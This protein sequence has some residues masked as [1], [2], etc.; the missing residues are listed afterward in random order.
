MKD[1][2]LVVIGHL[3]KEKIV[4]SGGRETG[5]VLG[6]PCAYTSVAAARLGIKTGIVTRI[7]E[8]MPEDL[9]KVFPEVGIDIEGVRIDK[10]TTTNLLIYEK[11]GRKRLEFLKKASDILFDDIPSSYF[12][13][14]FFLL[15]P[16]DYEVPV[17][18][19]KSLRQRGKKL[20]MEL[21]GYGGAS[22]TKDGRVPDEKRLDFLEEITPYFD[23]VKGGREDCQCLFGKDSLDEEE[24]AER[25]I[26]WGAKVSIIT[27]GKEGAIAIGRNSSTYRIPSY[28]AEV[29]DITGAGDVFHAGF[30]AEYLK[31]SDI[32]RAVQF[33]QA[34]SSLVIEKTGGVTVLRMP[35]E[36]DVLERMERE[37]L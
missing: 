2:D 14:K 31:S 28:S 20:L 32:E 15:C 27:L 13:A 36:I 8:D 19:I 23:I 34:A 29:I 10:T 6:G 11:S 4:F 30:L 1:I 26:E 22:S 33:A 16:I 24:I 25:F 17:S 9:L 37:D 12:S 35:E 21:G 7:G 5:P 3:L 18:L